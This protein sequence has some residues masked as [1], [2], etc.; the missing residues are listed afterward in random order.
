M[1]WIC[2]HVLIIMGLRW[3]CATCVTH[4]SGILTYFGVGSCEADTVQ[5]ICY[6]ADIITLNYSRHIP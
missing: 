2:I 6:I 4:C 3:G 5:F 1:L